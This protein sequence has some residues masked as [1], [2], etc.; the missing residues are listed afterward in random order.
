MRADILKPVGADL[1]V[2]PFPQAGAHTGAPLP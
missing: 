2:G 1:R